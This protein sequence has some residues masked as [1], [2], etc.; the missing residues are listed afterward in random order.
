M[1]SGKVHSIET[2]GLVDGPGVR[3]VIFLSG[4]KMRCQ[5]CHNPETWKIGAGE[6]WT[7]K[8]M[9]KKAC[10]YKNYWKNN[11]GITISGGEPLL[12]IE[13]VTEIF[14]LAKEHGINTDLDTAGNP[15][16]REEPFYSKFKELMKYT[17]L[18]MLDLKEM[19]P[20]GHKKLTGVDNENILD[21][22]RYLSD[23]GKDMWI[24][25]VL[26]PG[27]TDG[28]ED[29]ERMSAYIGSL[30]TERRVEILPYHTLGAVKWAELKIPYP[31][32]GVRVPTEE[33]IKRAEKIL[34]VEK[35][36]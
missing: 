10:R 25:H 1:I 35:Y 26:V 19:N 9:F 12:Q 22:A 5:F 15:F 17:D 2:F 18:V 33:E 27:L 4:C 11:G 8:D 29:L 30:K 13:F 24:R 36:N 23:H 28:Q 21:M 31:L 16:T 34:Q 7:A 20:A 6:T 14:R 32:E 3:F